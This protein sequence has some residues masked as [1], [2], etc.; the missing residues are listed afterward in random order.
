MVEL[1]PFDTKKM[2]ILYNDQDSLGAT[3]SSALNRL[4][5]PQ[6]QSSEDSLNKFDKQLDIR[7]LS[8]ESRDLISLTLKCFSAQNY[9][10]NSRII[11]LIEDQEL[12]NMLMTNTKVPT[13]SGLFQKIQK[14]KNQTYIQSDVL[15][16]LEFVKHD[17]NNQLLKLKVAE[18]ETQK[19][20]QQYHDVEEEMQTTIESYKNIIQNIQ[21]GEDSSSNNLKFELENM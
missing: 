12:C 5:T 18:Q 14:I 20:K 9:F 15:L 7:T 4:S 19:Y 3:S 6:K 11:N 10:I 21:S 17:L 13:S 8:R 2:T 1:N 16:E